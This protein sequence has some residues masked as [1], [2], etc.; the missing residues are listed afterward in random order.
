MFFYVNNILRFE[1]PHDFPFYRFDTDLNSSGIHQN[2]RHVRQYGLINTYSEVVLSGKIQDEEHELII[3][4]IIGETV[5][6]IFTTVYS[7]TRR[8]E[9][10]PGKTDAAFSEQEN[11]RF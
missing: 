7:L 9:I 8:Y 11:I 6:V 1:F 10:I 4:H 5:S 2:K 3:G